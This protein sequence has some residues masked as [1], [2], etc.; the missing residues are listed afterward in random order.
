MKQKI[1]YPPPEVNF[2]LTLFAGA[3]TQ[4]L[5]FKGLPTIAKRKNAS[6]PLKK[7]YYSSTPWGCVMKQ[8][9]ANP[10]QM[11][12]ETPA[13]S[14]HARPLK[15]SEPCKRTGIIALGYAPIPSSSASESR[16]RSPSEYKSTPRPFSNQSVSRCP[17]MRKSAISE[18]KTP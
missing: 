4:S 10:F 18:Q 6:Y 5:I 14:H 16:G 13:T 9:I 11:F 2:F 1:P 15:S 3:T 17:H 7:I 8:M 12:H